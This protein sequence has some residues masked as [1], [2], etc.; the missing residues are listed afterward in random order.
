MKIIALISLFLVSSF[1]LADCPKGYVLEN[2]CIAEGMETIKK[3]TLCSNDK[4]FLFLTEDKKGSSKQ[5]VIK[6]SKNILTKNTTYIL[7]DNNIA[8]VSFKLNDSGSGILKA[9][10]KGIFE[11]KLVTTSKFNCH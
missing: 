10:Y 3:L 1:A 4:K 7:E 2:V 11:S 6:I 8:N 9:T 5:E